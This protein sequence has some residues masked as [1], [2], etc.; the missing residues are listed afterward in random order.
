MGINV[1]PAEDA[2]MDR[3]FEIACIAF[4][5]NEPLW[6]VM[7]PAHWQESGRQKGAARMRAIRDTT[8]STTYLKAVDEETGVI[9]G[10]AKWN[11]F[12]DASHAT[13]LDTPQPAGDHWET[14]DE[15][16]YAAVMTQLFLTERN[17]AI[18]KS[19]GHLVSLDILTIDPA[20]QRRGVGDALVKWGTKLADD[21]GVE[22]VVESSV[23]G[24]GLYEKNGFVF[25][26]DV[27]MRAPDAKW[28]DKAEGRIAWMVRPKRQ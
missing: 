24:R 1:A 26:K 15:S 12:S 25:V 6:D 21:M 4:D 11:F 3:V 18:K 2:D 9:M 8:P 27:V 19:G 13:N 14:E 16:S 5:R 22:A 23:F 10:M 20:Y 7:W 28:K 17:A